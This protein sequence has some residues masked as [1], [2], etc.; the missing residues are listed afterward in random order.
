MEN[1][2]AACEKLLEQARALRAAFPDIPAMCGVDISPLPTGSGF[3][4]IRAAFRHL[5]DE[6][7]LMRDGRSEG[8]GVLDDEI[9]ITES[10]LARL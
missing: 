3:T 9:A 4:D 6:M 7:V 5:R 2:R 10:L 1:M 8:V